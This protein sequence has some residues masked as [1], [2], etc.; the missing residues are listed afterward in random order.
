MESW[1]LHDEDDTNRSF[2]PH[3]LSFGRLTHDV[4]KLFQ[5]RARNNF[6][7]KKKIHLVPLMLNGEPLPCFSPIHDSR[8][9]FVLGFPSFGVF[10]SHSDRRRGTVF[11]EDDA[12]FFMYTGSHDR[13][14]WHYAEFDYD[15]T[16]DS[17][18]GDLVLRSCS[19]ETIDSQGS[20]SSFSF[21]N[22]LKNLASSLSD[23]SPNLSNS[24]SKKGRHTSSSSSSNSFDEEEIFSCIHAKNSSDSRRHHR[25]SNDT[26][27]IEDLSEDLETASKTSSSRLSDALS[28]SSDYG[29]RKHV[30]SYSRPVPSYTGTSS[31]SDVEEIFGDLEISS[32]S[33]TSSSPRLSSSFHSQAR[34]ASLMSPNSSG[35][36]KKSIRLPPLNHGDLSNNSNISKGNESYSSKGRFQSHHDEQ[37]GNLALELDGNRMD[38]K[39]P[40]SYKSRKNMHSPSKHVKEDSPRNLVRN[41]DTGEII[42]VDDIFG[43]LNGIQE[44]NTITISPEMLFG[45]R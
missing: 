10:E 23:C 31:S 24:F 37:D 36:T 27:E 7:F 25:D 17:N 3:P 21:R 6:Q 15:A 22:K 8:D 1:R 38:D 40:N 45:R 13:Y 19:L 35:S 9:I 16:R 20:S 42:H 11:I 14:D 18:E 30:D 2:I 44:V 32:P 34:F 39:R 28:P 33:S 41:L 43:G 4:Q 29:S 26:L 5:T 12:I